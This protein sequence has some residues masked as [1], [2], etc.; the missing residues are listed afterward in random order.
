MRARTRQTVAVAGAL[1]VA[2]AVTAIV[3]VLGVIPL[4]DVPALSV[5]PKPALPGTIAYTRGERDE[6][7]VHAVRGGED[8]ELRC[9]EEY[10]R[11][12]GFTP[13]GDVAVEVFRDGPPTALVLDAGSG[14]V[15]RRMR[16]DRDVPR[17][18]DPWDPWDRH[19]G[20]DG[21]ELD[22]RSDDGH[23]ELL[24]IGPDGGERVLLSLDGPR[25]YRVR[26][27]G[28][29]PDGR[30]VLVIDSA[31]RL[32][33]VSAAG[34]PQP[35]LVADDVSEAAWYLPGSDFGTVTLPED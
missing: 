21:S 32:L 16:P 3:L 9:V 7:C 23:A 30:F 35:R 27:A 14:E 8:R 4:P 6:T 22:A 18:G 17:P 29:S 19:T 1:V 15:V 2:L 31:G 24:V 5:Q 13:D 25:D 26:P 33:V 11:L 20:P 34:D 10:A 12:L 28:W